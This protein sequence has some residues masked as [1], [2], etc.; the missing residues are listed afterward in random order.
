MVGG[1][2]PEISLEIYKGI[3]SFISAIIILLLTWVLGNGITT[4]WAILQKRRETE[5]DTLNEF[6]K[7]YG[8]FFSI[9]KLWNNRTHEDD[10]VQKQIIADA[11]AAEGGVEAIL[12]KIATEKR[13]NETQ[14]EILGRFRQA[15]QRL[16][17]CIE[18]DKNLP[19]GSSDDPEYLTFKR[20]SYLVSCIIQSDFQ[21]KSPLWKRMIY[22]TI[23]SI[24]WIVL[25][26][27]RKDLTLSNQNA[28]RIITSNYWEH[29]WVISEDEW[30]ILSN[31]E[32]P[33]VD[34]V[35]R[36]H[37]QHI[38]RKYEDA[39][40]S[41]DKAISDVRGGGDVWYSKG[42]ALNKLPD[43][44]QAIEVFKIAGSDPKFTKLAWYHIGVA[45]SK[46]HHYEDAISA[47]NRVIDLNPQHSS[48]WYFIGIAQNK[49]HHY[50][51]AVRAF[52][53]VIELNP[54]DAEAWYKKGQALKALN[55]DAEADTAFAKAEELEYNEPSRAVKETGSSKFTITVIEIEP[56]AARTN[57]K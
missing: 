6:Y 13:L 2:T 34:L 49:L 24:C 27:Y 57:A 26:N 53:M 5:I 44:I 9:W 19:W 47:F 45:Q 12:V 33:K 17:E 29:H 41:F 38:L 10:E 28:M 55:R 1:L 43:Y 7:L 23:Y 35:V 11:Y 22:H 25:P 50:E 54:Q 16:R 37:I 14:L 21:I 39:I 40:N 30:G 52:N 46:L 32:S 51:D 20:L 8:N 42:L 18:A 48:S 36:G 15:Y 56:E 3:I 4:N 31:F